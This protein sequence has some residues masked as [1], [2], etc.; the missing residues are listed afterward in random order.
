MGNKYIPSNKIKR[1]IAKWEGSSMKTNRSFEAEAAAFNNVLPRQA[2]DILS[3]EQLDGLYSYSYNVGA[4]RFKD[5]II[6]ALLQYLN[7]QVDGN[8]VLKQMYADKDKYYRGL[9]LRRTAEKAMFGNFNKNQVVTYDDVVSTPKVINPTVFGAPGSKAELITS[10]AKP[11][12]SNTTKNDTSQVIQDVTPDI[13][14]SSL[15]DMQD[16]YAEL[17]QE[18]RP[19]E[20][21]YQKIINDLMQDF[22]NSLAANTSTISN[23]VNIM[24]DGGD[25]KKK[26][27]SDIEEEIIPNVDNG[28]HT[29]TGNTVN[30]RHNDRGRVFSNMP[31][32][33]QVVSDMAKE[34]NISPNLILN[35]LAKEGLPDYLMNGNSLY[36][37]NV[38][39]SYGIDTAYDNLKQK[40]SGMAIHRPTLMY[41]SEAE[42]E[43]GNIVHPVEVYT[44]FI[45]PIEIVAAE[46]KQREDWMK[47]KYGYTGADLETATSAS[48]NLGQFSPLLKNINNVR[49]YQLQD[50]NVNIPEAKDYNRYRRLNYS[51]VANDIYNGIRED[52][53]SLYRPTIHTFEDAINP[54]TL[55]NLAER[56]KDYKA[57]ESYNRNVYDNGEIIAS[58]PSYSRG[59]KEAARRKAANR[60]KKVKTNTPPKML[61]KPTT[62][63]GIFRTQWNS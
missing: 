57:Y 4:K 23:N 16:D 61:T 29:Y 45:D 44:N 27:P 58:N 36:D 3:Q 30:I 15:Y 54:N 20:D 9:R 31:G 22:D 1:Q 55:Y 60:N 10:V 11:D 40:L 39:E 47:K 34:Y 19:Q 59:K 13:D 51:D 2:L 43:H 24:A 41:K 25:T 37:T 38:F 7:G 8:A 50:Y 12:N 18:S 35:R 17:T 21:G 49:K 42:N 56:D 46:L 63:N 53:I 33:M 6:P 5:R 48:Y 28:G 14:F 52:E 26:Y 62:F 32:F